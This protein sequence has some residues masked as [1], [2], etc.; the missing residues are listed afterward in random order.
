[1]ILKRINTRKEDSHCLLNKYESGKEINM[2]D[3]LGQVMSEAMYEEADRKGKKDIDRIGCS[4]VGYQDVNVCIPVTIKT[5][6]EAGNAKTQCLGKALISSGCDNCAGKTNDVCKFTISQKLRVEV[7]VIFGAR[8]EV[9]KASVD[10]EHD[11]N[12]GCCGL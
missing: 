1:M 7:P 4:A 10:C 2:N 12:C 8:A 9:G 11:E 6:G 5:F 3:E